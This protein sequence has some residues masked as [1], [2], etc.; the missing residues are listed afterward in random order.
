M[1]LCFMER[2][3]TLS[4]FLYKFCR[5]CYNK[6]DM[7]I[8]HTG[9]IHIGAAFS[10][11]DSDKARLRQAEITDGFR[12]LCTYAR[13]NKIE[14]VLIAG[15]LFDDNA[16]SKSEKSEVFAAI[17]AAAPTH[18]FYV[19]GNHDDEFY[20]QEQLPQN[21]HLFSKNHGWQAYDLTE[22]ITVTGMDTRNFSMEKFG[23]IPLDSTRFNIMLLHGDIAQN[24]GKESIPLT[25]LAQKPIDYLALG[26]IHKPDLQSLRFGVRG[27]YRYCGCLEG[28]VFDEVGVRGFFLLDI[29]NG[30]IC[31]ETFYSLSTREVCEIRVD[32]TS[33]QNYA[34]IENA[35]FAAVANVPKTHLV[36]VV[37][38][39]VYT[40]GLQKE[41][42]L[43]THKLCQQFF[44]ARVDDSSRLA[45]RA[46]AY[47]NDQSL[48]G[49]FVRE[50]GRYAFNDR[51]RDE[52]LEIGLKALHGEN[53]DL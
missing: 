35:V 16:L 32:I 49:A 25:L 9:D 3:A 12:R 27:K 8:I 43:L 33:C 45:F 50:V 23:E 19:S 52:I 39:G 28:R 13:E 15:D 17:A 29:Q 31:D 20:A 6:K 53:I 26:H 1:P 21:L 4:F 41:I 46:E 47:E 40:L 22:N 36:K 51:Q 42:S 11:L 10:F 7:K 14:V 34:E 5:I 37:L 18:F 24:T 30:K 38:C 48:C 44:H 2:E